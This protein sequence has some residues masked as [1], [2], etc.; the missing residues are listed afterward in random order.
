M[1]IRTKNQQ[2]LHPLDP[3]Y[4]ESA[5]R[6]CFLEET[7][8]A[9]VMTVPEDLSLQASSYFMNTKQIPPVGDAIF[10]ASRAQLVPV[11]KS[12]DLDF[13]TIPNGN[14]WV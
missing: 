8:A 11:Q 7:E 4:A 14:P 10:C 1:R 12:G 5:R 2:R 13:I 6:C 9:M 3:I